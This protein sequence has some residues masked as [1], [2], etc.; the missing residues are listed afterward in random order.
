M[1]L[2]N[3]FFLIALIYLV[4]PI[5][6]I[7]DHFGWISR[8]DDLAVMVYLWWKY[9]KIT[10]GQQGNPSRESRGPGP[11]VEQPR[12]KLIQT[13]YEVLGVLPTASGE[14]LESRYKILMTQY[15]P[16]K[17]A[18]LGPELRTLAH[19]K[20]LEIKG[21]YERILATREGSVSR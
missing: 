21:A 7:P 13:P 2:R 18:H 9:K 14:E 8:I 15:H 10:R 12:T 19:E 16:D 11:Q 17:V 4:S 6:L 3:L 5:D 1:S 20:T